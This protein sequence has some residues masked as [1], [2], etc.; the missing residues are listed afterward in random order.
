MGHRRIHRRAVQAEV[1]GDG[2]GRL[3][4]DDDLAARIGKINI[5]TLVLY[6]AQDFIV[7]P[8]LGGAYTKIIPKSKSV[9]VENA[10][11]DIQ[12]EQPEVFAKS[13]RE[14]IEG[15]AASRATRGA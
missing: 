6:G 12:G 7:Q 4:F 15:A 11:H 10:G 9:T 14:F 2:Y 13:V 3:D 1:S 5:P 8:S